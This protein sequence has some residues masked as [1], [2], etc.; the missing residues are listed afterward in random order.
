MQLIN[1]ANNQDVM[2]AA[3]PAPRDSEPGSNLHASWAV[4]SQRS[5]AFRRAP[6]SARTWCHHLAQQL[7]RP[8]VGTPITPNHLTTLRAITGALACVAFA[9]GSRG[10]VIWG[11]VAWTL[12]ALL[13]RADGE[14]ARLTQQSSSSG[15]LYDC[16][17]DIWVNACLFVAVGI[18][19]RHSSLGLAAV[20][21]GL[22]CG[23]C[24]FLCLY[25]SEEIESKLEPGTVVLGG[26]RGFDPDDLFYLIGPLAWIGAF[27]VML[28]AG[29]IVLVPAAVAIGIWFWRARRRARFKPQIAGREAQTR[30][31]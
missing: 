20:T 23:I 4:A 10:A 15:H 19:Q 14:L 13:D 2:P 17:V 7:V 31:V 21:L 1:D 18:G 9:W 5:R 24:L 8:L 27:R 12:S 3:A 11:G 29:S 30:N 26:V 25:W 22:L 6:L 16:W 28:L